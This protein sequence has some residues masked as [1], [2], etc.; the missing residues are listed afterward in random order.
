MES[1]LKGA[2]AS[3]DPAQLDQMSQLANFQAS[4]LKA[5]M[6]SIKDCKF[7]VFD[8]MDESGQTS[9]I[10]LD[11]NEPSKKGFVC[12]I[13]TSCPEFPHDQKPRKFRLFRPRD[14]FPKLR[15]LETVTSMD[16]CSHYV[17][18]SYCWPETLKDKNGKM[19]SSTGS[20]QV[21]DL[22][23]IIRANRAPDHVIDRAVDVANSLGLRMIWIDQEC[24]P[25]PNENSSQEVK[26]E[27]EL[28]LQAMDIIYNRAIMTAGLQ[29]VEITSQHQFDVLRAL[30]NSNND[31]PNI[32]KDYFNLAIDFFDQ[33]R[34]DRWYTRAWVIQEAVSAG[35]NLMLVFKRAA[36]VEYASEFRFTT[37]L[38][39]PKHSLDLAAR[40][41]PSDVVCIT[42]D[43]FQQMVTSMKHFLQDQLIKPPLEKVE[44]DDATKVIAVAEALHPALMATKSGIFTV[45]IYCLNNY[46]ARHSVNAAGALSLLRSRTCRDEQDLIA[47]VANLCR[48][49]IRLNTRAVAKHCSSLRL[50]ILALALLNGDFSLLVPELYSSS[51]PVTGSLKL[52]TSCW[53]DPFDLGVASI[54]HSSIRPFVGH[55]A[56]QQHVS[57]NKFGFVAYLWDV[58]DKFDF[59]P[60]KDQW[61]HVWRDLKRLKVVVDCPKNGADCGRASRE[62]L[63]RVC[64]LFSSKEMIRKAKDELLRTG[65]IAPDSPLWDRIGNSGI[66]ITSYLNTNQVDS[67]LVMQKLI[68]QIFF[69]I[70]K[71]LVS[72]AGKDSRAIGVANSIWQSMRVDSL[73]TN[74]NDYG[75]EDLETLPDEVS[76][77]LFTHPDVV[78]DP[79][80]TLRFDKARDGEYHQVWLFDRIMTHGSLWVGSYRRG[81]EMDS[82]VEILKQGSK[83]FASK[84]IKTFRHRPKR[85]SVLKRQL[86]RQLDASLYRDK[87]LLQLEKSGDEID[88]CLTSGVGAGIS[89]V[90]RN[91]IWTPEAEDGR[92]RNLVSVFDVDGPC[93]IA[94]PYDS[95]WEMLPHPDLRSMSICWLIEPKHG[96]INLAMSGS[97]NGP[98][99]GTTSK[100]VT[101]NDSWLR[102][103]QDALLQRLSSYK[104]I[105]VDGN[106]LLE[107]EK[108]EIASRSFQVV[109]K[110]KGMWAIMDL[111]YQVYYFY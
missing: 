16:I 17:A 86:G 67:T 98:G 46:G 90:F 84:E 85:P 9:G 52:G 89:E 19:L 110:V 40:A 101:N 58:E 96:Q 18:V 99:R 92:A 27:Q 107:L 55:R 3:L 33:V 91:G 48:Y 15:N 25:Q 61:A 74:G 12:R 68:A 32:R 78:N 45:N 105:P 50:A 108:L 42:V 69:D 2:P 28:G 26:D 20:Y 111:P 36:G 23:G 62:R 57:A 38:I 24:L 70:L 43:Q 66:Q 77:E 6:W 109:G 76:E 59:T 83:H 34:Q 87:L 14:V 97:F 29:D 39:P 11:L 10:Y 37:E 72:M 63:M 75:D 8:D 81:Y 82:L 94:I 5:E 104:G 79:F 51:E 53:L 31:S 56:V 103:R 47:I 44:L 1:D 102:K 95:D 7:L 60:I 30:S 106:S 100:Q 35:R 73:H 88:P 49:E 71:F 41:L 93:L 13:C 64:Q 22:N 54:D 65:A 21:R 4:R 80:K